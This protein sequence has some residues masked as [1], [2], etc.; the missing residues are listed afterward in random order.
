MH[1]IEQNPPHSA[2]PQG[3]ELSHRRLQSNHL[4]NDYFACRSISAL[5]FAL[6]SALT[7]LGLFA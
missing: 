3:A 1:T 2:S 7:A 6:V 5:T 4:S